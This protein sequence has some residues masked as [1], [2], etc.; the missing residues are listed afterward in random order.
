[1]VELNRVRQAHGLPL[2]QVDLRLQTAATERAWQQTTIPSPSHRE[3]EHFVDVLDRHGY[4]DSHTRGE[5]L[6]WREPSLE[7]PWAVQLWMDSPPHQQIV[8]HPDLR[9]VGV[10]LAERNQRTF[11]C[12]LFGDSP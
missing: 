1:V 5:V 8:L 6:A 3:P 10:G 2:L 11:V 12:A 9:L 7:V 4:D